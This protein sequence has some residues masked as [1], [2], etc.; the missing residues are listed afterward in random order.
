L[1][2]VPNIVTLVPAKSGPEHFA[3]P[4]KRSGSPSSKPRGIW[5]LADQGIVSAGNFA[6]NWVCAR[7]FTLHDFGCFALLFD[8]MLLL[9]AFTSAAVCYPLA[10]KGAGLKSSVIRR[11]ISASVALTATCL[12]PLVGVMLVVTAMMTHHLVGGV[13]AM[14]ALIGW[15][16]QE[17]ARRGLMTQFRFFDAIWGDAISYPGQAVVMLILGVRHQLTLETAFLTIGCTSFVSFVVQWIQVGIV[18]VRSSRIFSIGVGFWRCGRWMAFTNLASIPTI[19]GISWVLAIFSGLNVVAE[20]QAIVNLLRVANPII[21]GISSVIVPSAA[22]ARRESGIRDAWQTT[23]RHAMHGAILLMPYF[24]I[25]LVVPRQ[26]LSLIYGHDSPYVHIGNALRL[27]VAA[28]VIFYFAQMVLT[29]LA[30]IEQPRAVFWAQCWTTAVTILI[31]LPL[32]A[33]FGLYGVIG[34]VAISILVRFFSAMF[35]LRTLDWSEPTEVRSVPRVLA[36]PVV[37]TAA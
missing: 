35:Y 26:A 22:H 31:S 33:C 6:T 9:N 32:T 25:L 18:R 11:Y 37:Q 14:V 1:S 2:S 28:N 34:G 19:Q 30:A 29:F 7:Y 12:I 15:Q 5:G 10:V 20:Y 24:M 16:L 4:A 8:V 13:C 3:K 36:T 27:Y 23:A 17:T 21:S